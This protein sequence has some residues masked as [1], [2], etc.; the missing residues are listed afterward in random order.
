[1]FFVNVNDSVLVKCSSKKFESGFIA[2]DE[3][4]NN[5]VSVFFGK[6]KYGKIKISKELIE[7]IKE[8]NKK[9]ADIRNEANEEIDNLIKDEDFNKKVLREKFELE[10]KAKE[11]DNDFYNKVEKQGDTFKLYLRSKKTQKVNSYLVI[12]FDGENFTVI[13]AKSKAKARKPRKFIKSKNDFI[14]SNKIILAYKKEQVEKMKEE[15]E[16]L[17][18]IA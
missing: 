15:I 17:E 14:N 13:S 3:T 8:L 2:I 16:L 6:R 9:I 5:F 7:T 12:A 18:Q 4:L 11:K 10:E 1:M